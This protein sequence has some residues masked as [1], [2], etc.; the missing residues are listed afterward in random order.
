MPIVQ[1]VFYAFALVL[2]AA[3]VMVI[4]VR[5]PVYA[6][7]FLVLAFFSCTAIWILL[8]AEFL[9]IVLVL[10]YVGAVMVLFL[11]VVMMLDINLAPL[12]MDNP[13]AQSKSEIKYME[14]ALVRAPT[15]ASPT[16][17]YRFAIRPGENVPTAPAGSWKSNWSRPKLQPEAYSPRVSNPG[18]PFSIPSGPT[19]RR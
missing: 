5:N 12:V 6:A 3:S 14:A 9:A 1:I 19:L 7:L 16:D 11:F 4:T 2:T 10:V 13:F 15:I 8:E 18:M 17:A